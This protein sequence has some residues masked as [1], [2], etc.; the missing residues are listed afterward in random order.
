MLSKVIWLAK[1]D[2]KHSAIYALNDIDVKAPPGV[3]WKLLVDARNWSSYFPAEDQVKIL[4][5]ET[6]LVLGTRYT[7]VTVGFPM[8]LVI[9]ECEPGRRLAW[10][11]VVDGD[12]TG[13]SAY[14]GWVI[15]PTPDGY[16]VLTEETQQGDFFLEEIGRKHPGA[17]YRYH[18]EWVEC[19]ARAAEAQVAR[20]TT[21]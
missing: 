19:L 3:V 6:E 14:H 21:R 11:T 2:P 1:Y 17:L 5:G 15:T 8:S 16:H 12:E 7:R 20:Q 4:N 10:S 18:Q 13:S 9:T